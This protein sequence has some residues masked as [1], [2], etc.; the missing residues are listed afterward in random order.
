[1]SEVNITKLTP[2]FIKNAPH[3]LDKYEGKSAEK[4][5]EALRNHI[6]SHNE[7][8]INPKIIGL[9]GEW[10]SGKS[11]IIR[12]LNDLLGKDYF[13]FE[14]DAWG[15]Q[16]DLQRRSFLETLTKDL[17]NSNPP[18]LTGKTSNNDGSLKSTISWE[19][20]LK[21]LLAK[22]FETEKTSYPKIG[23]GIIAAFFT[24]IL[25]PIFV[26]LAYAL[27][28]HQK[29]HWGYKFLSAIISFFPVIITFIIWCIYAYKDPKKYK[30]IHYL[31]AVFQDKVKAE[32]EFKTVSEN[33]PSV[34]EFKE[35]M[36][37][38][39]KTITDNKRK[40]IIVFDNMDRL[41]SEKVKELWSSIHTFFAEDQYDNIWVIIPFDKKHLANAWG[42]E[43]KED[44]ELTNHFIN[45]TFP[46]VYQVS[47]PILTDWKKVFKEYFEDAFGTDENEQRKVIQRIWGIVK[48]DFTPRSIINFINELV[49]LKMLW[50]NEIPLIPMAVFALLKD[51]IKKNTID[52]ILSGEYLKKIEVIINNDEEFQVFI[53]ALIYGI[54]LNIAKQIPLIQYLKET[55]RGDK[56]RDINKYLE[57]SHFIEL[58]DEVI[59][60][61]D[62]AALD[63]AIISMS[64]FNSEIIDISHSWDH[65]SNMHLETKTDEIVFKDTHKAL[66]QNASKHNKKIFLNKLL[67]DYRSNVKFEGEVFFTT[68]QKVDQFILDEKIDIIFSDS[69]FDKDVTPELFIEYCN[70]AKTEYKKYRLT[71]DNEDLNKY[72][73][74]LFP[75]EIPDLSFIEYLIG[76]KNYSFDILN[77]RIEQSIT[78][79][80]VSSINFQTLI[81]TQKIICEEKPVSEL[82][83][84]AQIT[85]LI[86]SIEDVTSNEYYDLVAM[87]LA[88]RTINTPFVEGLDIKIAEVI[89]YYNDYGTLLNLSVSWGSELLRKSLKY[90]TENKLS[91]S[92]MNI[93]DVLPNFDA[94]ASAIN[95]TENDLLSRLNDWADF[96]PDNISLDTIETIIPNYK[97]YDYTT[98]IENE[99]SSFINTLAIDKVKSIPSDI[100]FQN[101]N[102]PADY[103][104]NC[105]SSLINGNVLNKLPDNITEFCKNLL[106]EISTG[107]QVIPAS[108]SILDIIINKVHKNRLQPK[109]NSICD[110]FCNKT[111]IVTPALFIYFASKFNFISKMTARDADITRN[112]L[113]V[114]ISDESCLQ[115]ILDNK[116]VYISKIIE[117]RDDAQDLKA[118]IKRKLENDFSEDLLLF[119]NSIGI[120]MKTE[121]FND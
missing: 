68:M 15:H 52:N 18:I 86:N 13:L 23:I 55:L 116:D 101:R 66:L 37:D 103:W 70:V 106:E 9:D 31:L 115:S 72:I 25:T 75:S 71:C 119:A 108:G 88:N 60:D 81:K 78:G 109:L 120:E 44:L 99:L 67:N 32:T 87:S 5:S 20:K 4:V 47:P 102:T 62:I 46:V 113:G 98:N 64:K 43:E 107:S 111:K 48:I 39:S 82:M 110:D 17:I 91:D 65:L 3:G 45:K 92:K 118:A 93:G 95:V 29:E 12:I 38:L 69:I 117:A 33:E 28:L 80:E 30:N 54:E 59:G 97:F 27:Q 76:D 114:V 14:Y 50:K 36:T 40:L 41:P 84:H 61:I 34:S 79:N 121:E 112:I 49:S 100:L 96:A 89:E 105:I 11:N 7:N 19:E 74:N 21:Y 22:K 83:T 16:E 2:S 42:I 24:A 90:L 57:H 1:M 56:N 35:W 85:P 51:D 73:I 58:F 104:L 10:G 63:D 6:E 26:Y 77:K 53:T 8:Q 94:I